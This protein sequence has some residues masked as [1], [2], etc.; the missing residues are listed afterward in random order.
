V[1]VFRRR[2]WCADLIPVIL[3]P[4][5]PHY[6]S[7]VK[8]PG[9]AFLVANPAPTNKDWS[10]H[11][12]WRNIHNYL[13]QSLGG[14]CVYCASWTPRLGD[15]FKRTDSTSIDHFAPKS[16]NPKKAYDWNNFRL[17][18]ARLNHRKGEHTDVLDPCAMTD[19]CFVL[20]FSTFR[21]EPASGLSSS[22]EIRVKSTIKRLQLNDDE[23]YVAQRIQV[24]QDYCLG[25]VSIKQLMMK[26]PFIAGEI[27]IQD[28]D[29][30][31]R[32]RWAN[33]FKRPTIAPKT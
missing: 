13:Y 4:P 18:R 17:C 7:K 5:P 15:S 12:Y 29:L 21:I 1:G 19:R 20:D 30:K 22:L 9:E 23:D 32:A 31:F 8:Q 3:P 33:Y 14:I 10:L 2:T 26:Y 27:V 28:F 16:I 6:I 25:K 11:N 24:I